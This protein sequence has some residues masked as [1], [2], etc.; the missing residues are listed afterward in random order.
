MYSRF[1]LVKC[2]THTH[3]QSSGKN[4]E[5]INISDTTPIDFLGSI[6]FKVIFV[7]IVHKLYRLKVLEGLRAN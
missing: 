4:S 2:K 5:E 6:F 1:L 7:Y 3:K